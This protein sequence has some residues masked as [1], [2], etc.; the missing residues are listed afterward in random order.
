[1][2]SADNMEFIFLLPVR[3]LLLVLLVF[4]DS[5]EKYNFMY[6]LSHFC[7]TLYIS[8]FSKIDIN[9]VGHRGPEVQ[10]MYSLGNM[11]GQ[12]K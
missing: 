10:N 11:L 5:T 7:H 4:L 3:I 9:L 6:F 1:M 12:I 8:L 2:K